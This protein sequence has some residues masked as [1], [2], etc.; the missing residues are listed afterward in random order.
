MTNRLQYCYRL[1]FN[2]NSR[3]ALLAITLVLPFASMAYDTQSTV[4]FSVSGEIIQP[5]C[6]V[7]VPSSVELGTF[8]R[9]DLSIAGANSKTIPVTISLTECSPGLTQATVTFSGQPYDDGVWGTTI[10][11]NQ[12]PNGVEGLGLQLFNMDGKPLVNLANGVNYSFPVNTESRSG[13][14]LFAARMYS[15]SGN[16]TKGSFSSSVTLTFTYK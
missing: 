1:I 3:L 6:T 9:Q 10:Y 11:A 13:N 7:N 2:L 4:N 5:V 12:A 16:T 8:N 15:P 14:L